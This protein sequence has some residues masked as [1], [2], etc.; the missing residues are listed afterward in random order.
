MSRPTRMRD[1]LLRAASVLLAAAFC[2]P[3][4]PAAARPAVRAALLYNMGTDTVLYERN[5][6]L[7]NA[8]ASLTKVM[9]MF[10]A[11]DAVKA[12]RASLAARSIVGSGAASTG[13]STMRLRR[14]ERVSL[15]EL[16]LGMAVVSGNDAAAATAERIG[17]SQKHFVRMMNAKARSLGMAGTVFKNVNGLPAAGQR[18]TARDLLVLTRAYLKAHPSALR[19]H[20]VMGL[21][22]GGRFLPATN[23]LLVLPGVDGLK[24]GWTG[25]AGYNIIVTARR[26]AT[27]LVAIVLGGSSS[28]VR[29]RAA[30]ALIDAGFE[31]P[32]SPREVAQ[33]VAGAV[34]GDVA[35][36][37]PSAAAGRTRP[38]SGEAK[39]AR[40][41][42]TKG[43][44]AAPAAKAVRGS[45]AKESPA[46]KGGGGSK[47]KAAPA[48]K[49]ASSSR[50]RAKDAG[51]RSGGRKKAGSAASGAGEG[52]EAGSAGSGAGRGGS[53]RT[54]GA[55]RA[56]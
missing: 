15:E 53:S 46:A 33:A 50:E 54:A 7:A 48:A 28:Y 29:N 21:Q 42:E 10:L 41:T 22:R 9:T 36:P 40:G 3:P 39:A 6:R 4:S 45:K 24:T 38:R 43:S 47:A 55:K 34:A 14:G 30:K 11:L 44:P 18:T 26:G 35:E 49:A 8:P 56:K 2:C 25:D 27:R 51:T 37:G 12:G 31:H 17:G 20:R 32:A 16:L 23:A 19:F 13:G 5:G 1:L 52:R